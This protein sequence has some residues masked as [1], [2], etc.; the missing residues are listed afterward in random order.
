MTCGQRGPLDEY[1]RLPEKQGSLIGTICRR[2]DSGSFRFLLDKYRELGSGPGGVGTKV[3][4]AW[5]RLKQCRGEEC[6]ERVQGARREPI[7][8]GRRS[9]RG[10]RTLGVEKVPR[11]VT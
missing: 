11:L 2:N 9:G 6:E 3:K 10:C 5:K 4:K 8:W 1:G 7:S